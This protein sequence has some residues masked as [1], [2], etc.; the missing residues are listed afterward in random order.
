MCVHY[1]KI[2]FCSVVSADISAV[3]KCRR[4][5]TLAN[6]IIVVR[7]YPDNY[8]SQ[9]WHALKRPFLIVVALKT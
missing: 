3:F 8:N 5:Q 9:T 7:Y 2:P 6:I 4:K 1:E